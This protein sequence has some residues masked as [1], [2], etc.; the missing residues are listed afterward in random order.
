MRL[1]FQ[2]KPPRLSRHV[3]TKT[4]TEARVIAPKPRDLTPH[5]LAHAIRI[6]IDI[7][8]KSGST[9]PL[10]FEALEQAAQLFDELDLSPIAEP[11]S[12]HDTAPEANWKQIDAKTFAI[13]SDNLQMTEVGLRTAMYQIPKSLRKGLMCWRWNRRYRDPEGKQWLEFYSPD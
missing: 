6:A 5:E 13:Q 3:E 10:F 12:E 11:E 4:V 9:N 7:A 2:K 8:K 1:R